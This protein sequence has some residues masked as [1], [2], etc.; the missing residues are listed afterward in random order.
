MLA[1]VCR[2]R[3]STPRWS[4]SW[5]LGDGSDPSYYRARYY[6]AS[7]GRFLSADPLEFASGNANFYTYGDGNP[8]RSIDPSGLTIVVI[9]DRQSFDQAAAYLRRDP[10]MAAVLD[11]LEDPDVEVFVFTNSFSFDASMPDGWIWGKGG[12]VFWDPH[13]GLGCDAN[14]NGAQ[15]SPAMA[16]AHELIHTSHPIWQRILGKYPVH[17]YD[18]LEEQ[19]TINAEND[20]ARHLGEGV[21]LNHGG[22]FIRVKGP[23]KKP[24]DCGCSG[25]RLAP[26]GPPL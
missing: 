19:T 23:L 26:A 8:V 1:L 9:G 22:E 18:N 7:I 5:H 17:D 16:L 24:S 25:Q 6:D 2:E 3:N 14:G 11:E 20:V 15:M 10:G 21:R 13:A 4:R 12:D